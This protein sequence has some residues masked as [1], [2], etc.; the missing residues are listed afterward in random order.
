MTKVLLAFAM[1][2][3]FAAWRR[4]G[5]FRS[6]LISGHRVY[7]TTRGITEVF[8]TLTGAGARDTL[9]LD[10]LFT[11]L[12]PSVGIVTGVA[13]GLKPQWRPGD[14]LAAQWVSDAQGQERIASDADLVDLAV[15]CGA[16]QAPTLITLPR[17][18]RTVDEK[19]RL[20]AYGDAADMESFPV[21][22]QWSSRGIPTL[23]LRVIV[24]PVE[25]PMTCDFEAAMDARGQVRISRILAQL[26]R[27]P[28]LLPDF[29]RLARQSRHAL[30]TL[31]GFLDRF[32]EQLSTR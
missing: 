7:V 8:V 14:L 13:G 11:H 21:I 4:R 31:A 32:F 24:D 3:E 18:V 25:M 10:D 1:K 5:R 22:K 20:A 26:A 27:R 2:E 15:R 17:V 19:V 12:S 28:Q 23:A 16:K 6:S 30:K 9:H 29:L